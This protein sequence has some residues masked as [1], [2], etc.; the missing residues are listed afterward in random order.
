MWDN[1]KDYFLQNKMLVD[2]GY[3]GVRQVVWEEA[4]EI[5]TKEEIDKS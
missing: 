2:L 4:K 3:M 1:V 5:V